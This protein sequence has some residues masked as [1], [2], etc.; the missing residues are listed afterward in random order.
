MNIKKVF[1]IPGKFLVFL[2]NDRGY[3]TAYIHF[4]YKNVQRNFFNEMLFV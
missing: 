4:S 3:P 1:F 2:K